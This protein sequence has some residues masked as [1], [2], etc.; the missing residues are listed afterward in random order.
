M[1]LLLPLLVMAGAAGGLLFWLIRR[2]DR[3]KDV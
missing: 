3:D 1:T 2:P